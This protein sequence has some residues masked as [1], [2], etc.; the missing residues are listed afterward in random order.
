MD[1]VGRVYAQA[2]VEIADQGDE[3]D[4]TS[5]ELEQLGRLL[6]GSPEL[7]ELLSSRVMSTRERTGTLEVIFRGRVGDLVY[8]FL[9]VVNEKGRLEALPAIIQAYAVLLGQRENVVEADL[10]VAGGLSQEQTHSI[11]DGVGQAVG[12]RVVLREHVDPDL[13]GGFKVRVG[14]RLIDGSVATQLRLMRLALVDTG[15]EKARTETGAL[16]EP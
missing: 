1:S 11:A 13:I 16:I 3:L 5:G 6:A 9:Q 15:R 4:Q 10:F 14:D 2:L 12:R 7:L 8:R